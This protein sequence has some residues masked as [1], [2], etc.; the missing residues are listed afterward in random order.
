M[1]FWCTSTNKGQYFYIAIINLKIQALTTSTWP[2]LDY[3]VVADTCGQIRG[4]V[5]AD[6]PRTS[7]PHRRGC[8]VDVDWFL[9]MRCGHG[10]Q[11]EHLCGPGTDMVE[12][13]WMWCGCGLC[14]KNKNVRG[15]WADVDCIL[16][17]KCWHSEKIPTNVCNLPSFSKWGDGYKIKGIVNM[18][19]LIMHQLCK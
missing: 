5:S 7:A 2:L 13:L 12:M 6:N 19:Y 4:F 3:S 16:K 1:S 9:Q 10:S 18:K 17:T 11:F 8:G 15:H 14:S